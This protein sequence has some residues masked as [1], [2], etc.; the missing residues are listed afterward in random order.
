MTRL[1][2]LT[3]AACVAVSIVSL[4]AAADGPLD[5]AAVALGV[6]AIQSLEFEADGRYYQFGQ[7]PAPELPWP[8]FDVTGYTATLDYARAA[9][10]AKYR[11]VQVQEPGRARP[12]TDQTQDQYAVDGRSWNLTPAPTAI[13]A[14]LPERNAELWTSPQGFVKAARANAAV[15]TTAADGSAT[16]TFTIDRVFRYE[17]LV[18]AAGEVVRVRTVLDSP[19]TGDTPAEW[20]FSEYRDF[21]GVRFP[22]R[23][24]R[25]IADLP[26]YDLRVTA[27]RVNTATAFAVPP[28]I[29]AAPVPVVTDVKT[30]EL[31]PG[32]L[33]VTGTTHNSVIVDQAGGLI[34]VEAPL[35]EAR[36]DAVLAKV[37]ELFPGRPIAGVINTHAHFD[38]AGGLRTYVDAGVPVI[39]HARNA[40]YYARAWT[41]PRTIVPDRL[42]ASKR[43]PR[44]TTFTDTLALA[45]ARNPIE[46]HAIAGSGHNDAFAMVFLP[47]AGLLVEGDAW[48]PAA[49][50]PAAP[51]PLWINLHGNIQRLG[52]GV[53][54]IAPLHGTVQTIDDLRAA[55][56]PR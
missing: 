48:T 16:V 22:A 37:R 2:T 8:A 36:S 42:A 14:N 47:K 54:R 53:Q 39:T 34:V 25:A 35:T 41:A 55:I 7:A 29:V 10:H 46:I 3:G 24:E 44:F 6:D 26:W 30:A 5:R 43:A 18:S 13:P 11:R 50:R 33:F 32:V 27:V 19:V 15:V 45:D 1:Q 31:A 12:H 28:E 9:V 17:G 38:H 49:T 20:R 52:L 21:G 40:A 4:F 56:A 23:V 51:S